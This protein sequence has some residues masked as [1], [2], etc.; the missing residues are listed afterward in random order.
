MAS[1][2]G[3]AL[4]WLAFVLLL[5]AVALPV[6]ARTFVSRGGTGAAFAIPV[7]L[8]VVTLGTFWLGRLSFRFAPLVAVVLLAATAVVLVR[9]RQ[10]D[11]AVPLRAY[12]EAAAVFTAGFGLTLVVQ[13]ATP[14]ITAGGEAYWNFA[15]VQS[16]LRTAQLP[17][18]DPWFAGEPV[19]YYYG[20][21]LLVAALAELLAT[22]GRY[23][24]GLGKA[25]AYGAF[26]V[27]AYGVASHVAALQD[28]P[29]RPAGLLAA[30]VVGLA[31]NLHPPLWVGFSVLP[32]GV[33]GPLAAASPF[34]E[35]VLAGA[36]SFDLV[37]AA[38]FSF[39]NTDFPVYTQ[40]FRGIHPH[41]VS[42]PFLLL[43]VGVLVAYW[44]TPTE[45]RR[46][47]LG[48]LVVTTPVVGLVAL[49]NTWSL[50][51]ACGL[52][53]LTVALAPAHP[54]ALVARRWD[55]A[56]SPVGDWLWRLAAGAIVGVLAGVVGL[57]WVAP[58]VLRGMAGD[59]GI[60]V[61]PSRSS[62]WF[63]VIGY[64]GFLLAF[65]AYL[66]SEL[67]TEAWSRRASL[68]A[69]AV[70]VG[71]LGVGWLADFAGL[72]FVAPILLGALVLLGRDRPN[73]VPVLIVAGAGLVLLVEVAYVQE[74]AEPG[75]YNTV[76]KVY[77]QTWAVW[78]PAAGLALAHLAGRAPSGPEPPRWRPVFVAVL[79]I[80]L[81]GYGVVGIASHVNYALGDEAQPTLDGLAYL[82]DDHP[83]QAA[84]IEWLAA[85][86]GQPTMVSSPVP[87]HR[88]YR[89]NASPA[90]SLT[91]VPTLVGWNHEADY[92]GEAAYRERVAVVDTIYAGARAQR[93]HALREYDVTF[94]WV[95]ERERER[96]ATIDYSREPGITTAFHQGD[97]T[98]YRVDTAALETG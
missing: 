7:G 39:T 62:P 85:H 59:P 6:T 53:A 90:A 63:F 83:D 18:Q 60:G 56:R 76:Y 65:A 68:A 88:L 79:V 55:A 80:A 41:V 87:E 8:A 54:L 16:L 78:A 12:G 72:V 86:P 29:H 75:R 48:L 27:A 33:A 46:R 71:L 24:F 36:S 97:V 74:S 96:Y 44:Y 22:P 70:A 37:E 14:A 10:E 73:V 47:R 34:D 38:H 15:L 23:A 2:I 67:R 42:P 30:F 91:G 40:F 57:L 52:V 77:M 1:G 95:G 69:V 81:A 89:F 28:R 9:R 64:G 84:A 11:A 50:P 3:I 66:A 35:A 98:I 92:R 82:A 25:V 43:L 49:I 17:P 58:Y 5:G 61:L 31:S 13:A 45:D 93:A 94:I 32:A 20:G 26:V 4:G 51:T 21:H 19:R